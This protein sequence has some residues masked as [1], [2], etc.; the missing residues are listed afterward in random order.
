[1][2]VLEVASLFMDVLLKG[3]CMDDGAQVTQ[4][5]PY[6]LDVA[7]SKFRG[8][9]TSYN[10]GGGAKAYIEPSRLYCSHYVPVLDGKCS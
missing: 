7:S 5:Q 8:T 9:I 1:M 4:Q 10:I 2:V 3:T 6:N